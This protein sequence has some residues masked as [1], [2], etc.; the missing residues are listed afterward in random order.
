MKYYVSLS[1]CSVDCC[2]IYFVR[3]IARVHLIF[4][5]IHN[6]CDF[7]FVTSSRTTNWNKKWNLKWKCVRVLHD[8]LQPA[9]I[10]RNRCKPP[11]ACWRLTKG[12][13]LTSPNCTGRAENP[14]SEFWQIIFFYDI[15]VVIVYNWNVFCIFFIIGLDGTVARLGCRFRTYDFRWCGGIRTIL[16]IKVTIGDLQCSV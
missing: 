8:F 11:R 1:M 9:N 15:D 6:L 12:W 13:P 4:F 5:C 2:S 16:R 3:F 14:L 7:F 10:K